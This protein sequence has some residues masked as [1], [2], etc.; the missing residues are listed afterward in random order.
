MMFEFAFILAATAVVCLW[1][2]VGGEGLET[3]MYRMHVDFVYYIETLNGEV[4]AHMPFES[5][6]SAYEYVMESGMYY[7]GEVG[8]YRM[9]SRLRHLRVIHETYLEHLWFAWSVAF[10]L[11]V[12]GLLPWIWFG[13]K[14]VRLFP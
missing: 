4:N 9:A 6:E 7:E 12:H 1:L 10:V 14:A 2:V 13:M 5:Y 11:I 8:D 3:T